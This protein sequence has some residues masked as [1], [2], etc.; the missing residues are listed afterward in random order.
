MKRLI[1]LLIAFL[2]CL[3][4]SY[5]QDSL[6]SESVHQIGI[7]LGLCSGTGLTYRYWPGKFGVQVTF[8]G[9]KVNPEN[10]LT[11]STSSGNLNSEEHTDTIHEYLSIGLS[12]LY[13][14][15]Q[16]H[17]YK[18]VSYVGSHYIVS[19]DHHTYNAG[20]G[21]GICLNTRVSFS[22]M[23]GYGA[24]DILNDFKLYPTVELAVVYRIPKK[25]K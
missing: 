10:G 8:F 9:F 17:S 25:K 23:L 2:T 12:G 20:A 15:K 13:T 14:L 6:K 1:I 24:Y 22:F 16:F 11:Y 3:N 21:I 18:L 7:N 19:N 5:G 4:F